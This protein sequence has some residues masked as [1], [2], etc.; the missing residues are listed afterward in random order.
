MGRRETKLVDDWVSRELERREYGNSPHGSRWRRRLGS[1]RSVIIATSIILVIT[2]ALVGTPTPVRHFISSQAGL[3][4]C[5]SDTSRSFSTANNRVA[6]FDEFTTSDPEFV[7]S[8]NSSAHQAGFQFDYYRQGS[9]TLDFLVNLPRYNY[10]MIILRT[11]G[12]LD[13]SS[14]DF[15]SADSYS[16]DRWVAAQLLGELYA[17]NASGRLLFSVSPSFVK[18]MC[19][20]FAQ[21]QI[22]ALWCRSASS[23][24][25]A[26][27]FIQ[28]GARSYI[29]FDRQ[30]TVSYADRVFATLSDLLMKGNAVGYSVQAVMNTFGTDPLYGAHLT[31][32]PSGTVS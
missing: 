32:F 20:Q 6:M 31:Y 4:D 9:M 5:G 22:L 14:T 27:A 7:N 21:T 26:N 23:S 12:I 10:A 17:M 19:G 8:V 15:S 16:R 30:V 25:M 18:S 3:P 13:A 2:V 29:G 1:R 28:K 11:H 24:D